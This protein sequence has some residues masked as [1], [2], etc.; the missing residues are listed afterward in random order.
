[1]KEKAA[2]APPSYPVWYNVRSFFFYDDKS[3]S[4]PHCPICDRDL[5]GPNSTCIHCGAKIFV[6]KRLKAYFKP[7]TIET[8]DCTYCGGKKTFQYYGSHLERNPFGFC[9]ACGMS[10]IWI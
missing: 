4:S 6:D 2:V 5:D 8:R 3:P 7:V 10:R 9:T 1:M